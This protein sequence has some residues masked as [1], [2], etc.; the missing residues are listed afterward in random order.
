MTVVRYGRG[1]VINPDSAHT[2]YG[3]V[4]PQFDELGTRTQVK[5]RGFATYREAEMALDEWRVSV[6]KQ[7]AVEP[8]RMTVAQ[9]LER[10]LA[11]AC[12]GLRPKTIEAYTYSAQHVSR[13]IGG[14]RAQALEP[15]DVDALKSA[16]RR[17]T[18]DR[19][20]HNSLKVLRQ[21]LGWATRIELVQR[22][23]A[24]L[25]DLPSYQPEEGI[26]LSHQQARAFLAVADDATYSPLWLLYLSTGVRRGEGL[27][28]MWRDVD[29]KKGRLSIRNQVVLAKAQGQGQTRPVLAEVKTRSARRTIDLDARLTLALEEHIERQLK[30]RDSVR[31]WQDNDLVF[32]TRNGRILSPD[33]VRKVFYQLRS[34]SGMPEGFTTHDLRHSHASFLLQAGVPVVEVSRRLGHSNPSVTMKIYAHLIPGVE[35]SAPAAIERMLYGE[36][37]HIPLLELGE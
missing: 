5:V 33:N 15:R 18:S 4:M 27:G 3:Y 20:A 21:A 1:S 14:R 24:L 23:V 31:Y 8:S 2:T 16:L 9:L 6:N 7:M 19:V 26:A 34:L 35:R 37:S 13:R 32:C 36:T 11:S 22:N 29:P 12:A 17:E 25:V 30:I 28:L 10:W